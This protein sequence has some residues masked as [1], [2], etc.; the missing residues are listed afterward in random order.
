MDDTPVEVVRA[1]PERLSALAPVFGRAFVHEPMMLWPMGEHGDVADRFTRCFSHF[2]ER[3][4]PLGIVW[5]AGR[6][7]GA[8]A[9]FPPGGHDSWDDHPWNEPR[10][11]ELTDDG[12]SRY[13]A[14]WDWIGPRS[15]AEPSWELDSIAVEPALQGRGI[16]GALIAAGLAQA[17]ADGVG[18]FLSTGSPRNVPI[19][20]RHGFRRAEE[21]DAPGGGPRIWFMRWDP[22]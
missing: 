8:A 19:Y 14:F 15:P 22:R 3:A 21:L 17:R 13:D 2:L 6:A 10:I 5:E 16:G 1:A 11:A 18:A 9:W 20:E 4:L 7:L 12:G